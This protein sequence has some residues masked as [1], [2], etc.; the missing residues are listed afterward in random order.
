MNIIQLLIFLI[1]MVCGGDL[2]PKD[3]FAVDN[4]V[5]FTVEADCDYLNDW[6]THMSKDVRAEALKVGRSYCRPRFAS[7]WQS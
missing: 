4:Y 5:T 6:L 7:L 2:A 3:M 1:V